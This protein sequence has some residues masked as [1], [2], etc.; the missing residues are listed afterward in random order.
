M[1]TRAYDEASFVDLFSPF[2][3]FLSYLFILSYNRR[4][5]PGGL[6]RIKYSMYNMSNET[7]HVLFGILKR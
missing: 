2:F 3:L 6:D 5:S 1:T 4:S 7:D